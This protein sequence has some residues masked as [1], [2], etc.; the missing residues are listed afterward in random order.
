MKISLVDYTGNDLTVVN[1]ARVSMGKHK[2][3]ID[4]SD[5]KLIKY[6]AKNNHVSCFEHNTFT[7]RLEI[8]IFVARQL[9]RHRSWS[10]NEISGRYVEFEPEFFW[11]SSFRK[12]DESIKQGSK[13]EQVEMPRVA[14]EIY[15]HAIQQAYG[16]YMDLLAQGV[17]KE[18]ARMVLPLSLIT[19]LYAT[20]NLRSF[21]HFLK[22]RL[23]AHAQREIRDLAQMM[24]EK[25][26]EIP[27]DPFKYSLEAF[28]YE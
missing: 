6:L 23:D 19:E 18:Q 11:P 27:G 15:K 1:A 2:I 10:F 28:G 12:Q 8:P 7:F 4:D 24:L 13:D 9:M 25:V 21:V 14:R 5:I 3:Q 22:L 16:H 17:C 26:R 20:C